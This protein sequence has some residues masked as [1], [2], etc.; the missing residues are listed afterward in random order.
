MFYAFSMVYDYI[1]IVRTH[2]C[3]TLYI[4]CVYFIIIPKPYLQTI[5]SLSLFFF[6]D[7]RQLSQGLF[8]VLFSRLFLFIADATDGWMVFSSFRT[9]NVCVARVAVA[10]KRYKTKN[11]FH[12]NKIVQKFDV[13]HKDKTRRTRKNIVK[14]KKQQR[15]GSACKAFYPEKNRQ[16]QNHIPK[17]KIENMDEESRGEKPWAFF[18]YFSTQSVSIFCFGL[19]YSAHCCCRHCRRCRAN[20]KKKT[21][22][23][24]P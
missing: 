13:P 10:V 16:Q 14:E 7:V 4:L 18:S 20:E 15:N 6:F 8:S 2:C 17:K 11:V 19:L 1:R 9:E 23:T 12:R 3:T 5:F 24:N 22:R 21:K